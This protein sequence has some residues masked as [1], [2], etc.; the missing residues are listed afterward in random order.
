MRIAFD[1]DG[2]LIPAPGTTMA[3]EPLGC[4]RV[5]F[6]ASRCERVRSSCSVSSGVMDTRSGSTQRHCAHLRYCG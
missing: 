6:Q 2:T 5:P 4:W 3:V 1:L